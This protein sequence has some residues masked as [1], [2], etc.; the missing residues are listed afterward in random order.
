[1][2]TTELSQNAQGKARW[3]LHKDT[4]SC[5]K[6]ILEAALH[7][8]ACVRPL[9]SYLTYHQTRIAGQTGGVKTNL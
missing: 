9:T 5:F 6:Q 2:R 1:M 8:T 3:V 7:K 4:M